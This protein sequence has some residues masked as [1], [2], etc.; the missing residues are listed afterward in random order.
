M[1][2]LKTNKS[3]AVAEMGDR[4]HNKHGPKRG[5]AA[6]PLWRR[7]GT[8]SNTTWPGPRPTSIPS[9][10]LT[11]AS[12]WPQQILAE[13]WGLCPFEGG[14]LDPHLTQCG[15]GRGLPA[16]QVSSSPVQPFGHNT[17]TSQTG[18]TDNGLIAYG[19]PFYEQ[20]PKNG[21]AQKE[22]SGREV[23]GV[24]PE[25]RRESMVG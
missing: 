3:S 16:C 18:Q 5:K 15:Q 13:N 14:E 9:G 11:H 1:K 25:A 4:G 22:R 8:P 20:S 17:P 23:R 24:S 2:K 19:E 6:V 12:I 21:D 10:I 7:A